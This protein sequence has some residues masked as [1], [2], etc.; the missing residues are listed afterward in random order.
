MLLAPVFRQSLGQVQGLIHD[1]IT[2][3]Y[4]KKRNEEKKF[5]LAGIKEMGVVF[6][7]VGTFQFAVEWLYL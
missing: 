3:N 7:K 1:Y 2:N 6:G 4:N 5:G